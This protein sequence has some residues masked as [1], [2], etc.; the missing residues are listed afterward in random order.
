[1]SSLGQI[2]PVDL[3]P[4]LVEQSVYESKRRRSV[5]NAGALLGLMFI[6]LYLIPADLVVPFISDL[7]RPAVL[8]G[9]V[10]AVGWVVSRLHPKMII[11]GPQPMRWIAAIYFFAVLV[12][13]AAGYLRGLPGLEANAADRQILAVVAF[14]GVLL[15]AADGIKDRAGL[16]RV[17]RTAIWAGAIMATIG[18]VQFVTGN[19]LINY[20]SIPG[21]VHHS[22]FIIGIDYRAGEGLGRVA[23]TATHYIEF[24]AIMAMLLPFAIHVVRFGPSKRIR[25]IGIVAALMIAAAIPATLSRTGIVAVLVAILTMMLA[26]TWRFRAQMIVMMIGM[27]LAIMVLKPGQLG[28]FKSLFLGMGS[29][30]SI[31][32]RTDDYPRI[33]AY[34]TERPWFGRGLGTF[35]PNSYFI[36]DNEWLMH[37]VTLG[38]LGVLAL[39]ILFLGTLF[40]GIAAFR[41]AKLD[42]DRHLATCL[43]TVPLIGIVVSGTFDSFEFSSFFMTLGPLLGL[44][45]AMWRFARTSQEP[46]PEVVMERIEGSPGRSVVLVRGSTAAR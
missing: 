43:I 36:L 45:G 6:L 8:V 15:I 10:L 32:T 41:G 33:M 40:L 26:W 24:S 11:K 19:E 30:D 20:I 42:E 25:Q 28:A 34:F 27:L 39:T 3:Q 7:G 4:S 17:V 21:L 44:T 22:G 18:L 2:R 14:L 29:D 13:Y 31:T 46:K 5:I 35:L 23:S 16:D 12:G 1:M 37:A 38:V 9:L